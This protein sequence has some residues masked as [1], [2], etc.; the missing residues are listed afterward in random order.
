[1]RI[2]LCN[3][4]IRELPFEQQC[5]PWRQRI[6]DNRWD[7]QSRQ[8][9]PA[10]YDSQRWPRLCSHSSRGHGR[11]HKGANTREPERDRLVEVSKGLVQ[12]PEGQA[13][14]SAHIENAP[15]VRREGDGLV[16]IGENFT[17][18]CGRLSPQRYIEERIPGYVAVSLSEPRRYPGGCVRVECDGPGKNTDRLAPTIGSEMVL[19]DCEG[20]VGPLLS[21]IAPARDAR[22]KLAR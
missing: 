17:Q 8:I 4:V 6:S 2:W 13:D 20:V 19:G 1:M 22:W 10:P 18:S 12:V 16:G 21:G 7:C 14:L 5:G 15:V 9:A 11:D 3:E